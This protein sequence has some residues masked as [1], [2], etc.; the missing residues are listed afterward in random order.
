MIPGPVRYYWGGTWICAWKNTPNPNAAKEFIRYL[1][2]DNGFLVNWAKDT[3]D[4]VIN[5]EVVDKIKNNYSE[6]FLAGQNHYAA[7][8]EIARNVN[9]KLKQKTDEAIEDLF[10][11]E[12]DAYIEGEKT[13]EQALA[14]FRLQ[15]TKAL[16]QNTSDKLSV[17]LF[18]N[19]L[20]TKITN[21][22]EPNHQEV[23]FQ[24]KTIPME[25]EW[26]ENRLDPLLDPF[27]SSYERGA[28]DVFTLES[29]FV[30]KY[31]ASGLL[32]DLTDIYNA[33]KNKLLAYPVEVGTYKGKVYALPWQAYPGAMFY[34]RSLAKK[35]LGTD[36]PAAVQAYFSD[37]D[38]FIE[39]TKLLIEKSDGKCVVVSS[40]K[41][42]ENVFFSA[43]KAPW[44][45]NGRLVVDP[46]LEQYLDVCKILFDNMKGRISQWSE[47]W[48]DGMKDGLRDE[49]GRPVEVF[50]YFLP[51]WGLHYVLK[52]NTPQTAGDWAMIQGP[53]PYYW[54]G[55]WVCA[56]KNTRN[57]N[58]AR[59]L[60]RYL[61]TDNDFIENWAE[62][63]GDFVANTEVI[64]KIKDNYS[65][66][67]LAG[68]NHY[69]AF[70]EIAKNVNG[71]LKQKTDQIIEA[72]LDKE[73]FYYIYGE[74]TK[75]QALADF[76]SQVQSEL[77]F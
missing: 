56:R 63:I 42:L 53:V 35:Y 54:G 19:D 43:R 68:Q 12:V 20:E 67:Y 1:T 7:F 40:I 57:P 45:V 65:E 15:V 23:Q 8:A 9:G 11:E 50:S 34:R 41:D 37:P 61:T 76:K 32:L 31:V 22:F 21:Y 2:T 77:G 52:T 48:F 69:A 60:I 73:V 16:G 38:K 6:P 72:M 62:D 36:D 29:E 24:Y 10:M 55:T 46:V 58:A 5:T 39:T 47:G 66:P 17:W 44:V 25:L 70:A 18:N 49:Y 3:G 27:L 30:R 51:I 4:F 59:E 33:N 75:E 74:K 14:D 64:N 13:K 71:R 26:F 28:P